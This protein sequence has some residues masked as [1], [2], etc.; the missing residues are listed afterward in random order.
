MTRPLALVPLLALGAGC[1]SDCPE[2]NDSDPAIYPGAADGCDGVD[3]DCDGATDEDGIGG[4]MFFADRDSDGFGNVADGL[5]ACEQPEGYVAD[6]TDCDD[7][8]F[9]VYPGAEELCNDTDDDCDG[10]V[11]DGAA[12]GT[13][14]FVDVD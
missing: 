11:D 2:C 4:S 14:W 3:N 7:T 1:G 13:P 10:T 9:S 12:D 8:D 6:N 5:L